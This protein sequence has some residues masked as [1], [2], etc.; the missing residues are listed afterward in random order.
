MYYCYNVFFSNNLNVNVICNIIFLIF[1]CCR[2]C[3]L[4]YFFFDIFFLN[5]FIF[6]RVLYFCNKF[7]VV[8]EYNVNLLK[9]DLNF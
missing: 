8:Y 6:L 2:K 9:M 1:F 4:Y 3:F 7:I 5:L